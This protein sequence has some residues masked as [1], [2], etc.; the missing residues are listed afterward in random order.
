MTDTK[1]MPSRVLTQSDLE[2][3]ERI[4]FKSGDDIA[5]SIGRSFERLEERIDGMESRL[6][7]RFVELEDTLKEVRIEK[8]GRKAS[9]SFAQKPA[10]AQ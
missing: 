8:V 1:R 6:Y 4:I 5:V 2:L 3:M 9:V 7:S 10:T